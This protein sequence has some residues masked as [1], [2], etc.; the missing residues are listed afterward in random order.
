MEQTNL[1]QKKQ[2]FFSDFINDL[3]INGIDGVVI[4][5]FIATGLMSAGLSNKIIVTTG[6]VVIIL[7]ALIM[8]ISSYL[9]RRAEKNQFFSLDN[10]DILD[11]EDIKE[12]RLLENLGIG[13]RIQSLAQ[14]EIEKDRLLWRNLKTQLDGGQPVNIYEQ[15]FRS[16]IITGASYIIGGIIP[17]IPYFFTTD[18]KTGLQYSSFLSLA[19]LFILGFYK[20]STLKTP[21]IGG[22]IASL[23]TGA[24]VGIAG[25][26]IAKLFVHII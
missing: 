20:S 25:Y 3:F 12:K 6:S 11:A 10:R 8:G 16:A 4:V 21:L 14:E 5:F 23:F 7:A 18:I 2:I 26:L 13:K 17:L 9:A 1:H 22:A 24:V 19:S 15:A